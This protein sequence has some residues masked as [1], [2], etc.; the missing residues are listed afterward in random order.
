VPRDPVYVEAFFAHLAMKYCRPR[1][2]DGLE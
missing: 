2:D 1:G